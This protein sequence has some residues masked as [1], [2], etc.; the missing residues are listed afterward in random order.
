MGA[1]KTPPPA[2]PATSAAPEGKPAAPAKASQSSM[3]LAQMA[4]A[5]FWVE[6]FFVVYCARPE[7]WI[8]GLH[9][10]PLAK[11]AGLFAIVAFILS[12]SQVKGRLPKEVYYL[13]A[14]TGWMGVASLL[15]PL[16]K[17]GAIQVTEDF[18][19]VVLIIIV[20]SMC[21]GTLGRLRRLMFLQA[22]SAGM[23][24]AISIVKGH[25][26]GGRLEGVLNGIYSNPND[27]A[28]AMALTFPFC[29]AFMIRAKNPVRKTYWALVMLVMA[30]CVLM[31]ASRGGLIGLLIGF[32]G[33]TWSYGV[34]QKRMLLVAGTLLAALIILPMGGKLALKRLRAT[35][36]SSH[37]TAQAYAS[38]QARQEL[39][40][41]GVKVSLEHPLFGVG[42]GDFQIISGWH[43]THDA[44][45]QL[46]AEAGI[47]ALIIF[48]MVFFRAFQNVRGAHQSSSDRSD[49]ALMATAVRTDLA[50]FA[51][52]SLFYPVAYHFFVYFL[53]AYATAIYRI[54]SEGGGDSPELAGKPHHPGA[55]CP[56]SPIPLTKTGAVWT[57]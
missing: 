39:L 4:G 17:G 23:I 43:E 24:A 9:V 48:L 29:F 38:A 49:L 41:L 45:L 25:Q 20:M 7:D 15:S 37:E 32:V 6:V 11:V 1:I 52:S 47:P 14:L 19:K 46:S 31:T 33:C 12:V 44:Y 34:R 3:R 28:L 30:Y 26:M 8:P 27:L 22:A 42:P 2:L 50:I 57:A 35:V 53:F 10:I 18:A 51:M 56:T 16:W 55:V 40:R 36:D 13:V 54:A 21:V 5:F